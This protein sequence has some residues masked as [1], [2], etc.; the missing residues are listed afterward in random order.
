MHGFL[1]PLD[2]PPGWMTA[3]LIVVALLRPA[4]P[5]GGPWEVVAGVAMVLGALLIVRAA[6]AELRRMGTSAAPG[7]APRA[8]VTTGVFRHSRNPIY[9]AELLIVIGA[10]LILRSPVALLVVP[11][12]AFVLERRFIRPEERRLAA[13]FGPAFE[14]YRAGTRRWFQIG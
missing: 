12:L 11:G 4:G 13:A 6:G 10:A 1:G 14:A 3:G 8:L 7:A 9:L 5:L 2:T